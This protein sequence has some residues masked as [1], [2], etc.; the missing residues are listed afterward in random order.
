[1]YPI[2]LQPKPLPLFA[3][4]YTNYIAIIGFVSAPVLT[5]YILKNYST[6]TSKIA[7]IIANIFSPL[8]LL[9]LIIYLI[10]IAISGKDP[11]NDRN[12]LLIFNIMLIGVMAIIVFSVSGTSMYGKQRFNEIILFILSIITLIINLIALSAIIYRLGQYGLTPNKLAILGS[13]ILIFVN[14]ILITIDLFKINFKKSELEKVELTIAKYL[15]V[16]IVWT[17]IVV[18]GFPAI[19]GMR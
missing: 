17:L 19:F 7:P 14:L 16:Y 6:L 15:P 4:F 5:S 1:M 3:K 12:F 18:F 2:F 13:N 11:Y 9:T 8:V 10:T